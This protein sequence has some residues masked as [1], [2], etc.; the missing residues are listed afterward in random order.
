MH[1]MAAIMQ[2]ILAGYALRQ[3]GAH[4][5]VHWARVLENGLAVAEQNGAREVSRA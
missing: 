5:V 2:E 4:G 3:R 1:D